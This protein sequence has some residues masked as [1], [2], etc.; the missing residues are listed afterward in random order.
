M[1][2]AVPLF[3]LRF[4]SAR[5]ARFTSRVGGGSAFFV[6]QHYTFMNY[7]III[8]FVIGMA[9]ALTVFGIRHSR[10]E[11]QAR[12]LLG[13]HPGAEQTS[14]YLQLYSPFPWDKQR[15]M[16]AK[17]A[18]M[19]QQGWTFLRASSAS[20]FRA[21]RSWGGGMTLQFIRTKV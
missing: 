21:M 9:L 11:R 20:F 7:I 14:V 4:T 6:R 5:Q 13:Q 1:A 8:P 10:M 3:R 19:Q 12:A 2:L 17:I 16:D 15:E 18:E